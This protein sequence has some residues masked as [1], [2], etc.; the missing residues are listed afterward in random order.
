MF[1]TGAIVGSPAMHITS[2]IVPASPDIPE[3]AVGMLAEAGPLQQVTLDHGSFQG[4]SLG[5]AAALTY[6][7]LLTD[8]DLTAGM[9]VAA[10][11]SIDLGG[12]V[13]PVEGITMKARAARAAGADVLFVPAPAT[14]WYRNVSA[15][16]ANPLAAALA[17]SGDVTVVAV[18]TLA[19]A[20]NWLC[21]H[22]GQ[23]ACVQ[24]AGAASRR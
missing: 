8:G 15:D 11:G 12:H 9:T 17:G 23:G 24:A 6:V 14:W 20:V 16:G 5:L 3:G 13:G 2:A 1:I 19:D 21:E 18:E 4:G 10:T 22:G 7:D